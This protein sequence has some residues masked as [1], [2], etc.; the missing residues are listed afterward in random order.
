MTVGFLGYEVV[1]PDVFRRLLLARYL[2]LAITITALAAGMSQAMLPAPVKSEQP[3]VAS[4][5]VE[6]WPES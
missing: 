2:G 6:R 3:L 1:G 5:E 4:A